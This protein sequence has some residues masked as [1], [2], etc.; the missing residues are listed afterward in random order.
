MTAR[1]QLS[2]VPVELR[3]SSQLSGAP[4][5][6]RTPICKYLFL[7]LV[8]NIEVVL[9]R[10]GAQISRFMCLQSVAVAN[11]IVSSW[12]MVSE[13]RCGQ[14]FAGRVWWRI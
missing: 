13:I 4:V 10:L 14:N 1:L 6:R 3:A 5:D 7:E 12:A 9:A 2:K 11:F 8:N